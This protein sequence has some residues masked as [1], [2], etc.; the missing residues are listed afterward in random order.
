[1]WKLN[2]P[3]VW[4]LELVKLLEASENNITRVVDHQNNRILEG[5]ITEFLIDTCTSYS[6]EECRYFKGPR[7]KY[8]K[9]LKTSIKILLCEKQFRPLN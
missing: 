7:G 5:F 9:S 4:I 1:M 3:I 2:S 6:E 8:V